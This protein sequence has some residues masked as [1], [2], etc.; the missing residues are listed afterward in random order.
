MNRA[1]AS[2]PDVAQPMPTMPDSVI[3]STSS[4]RDI[5]LM[6]LKYT[7][8]MEMTTSTPLL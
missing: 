2:P 4:P 5:L 3:E 8:L 7:S 6:R 1:V